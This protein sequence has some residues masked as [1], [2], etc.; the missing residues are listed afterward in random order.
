MSAALTGA[1]VMILVWNNLDTPDALAIDFQ[2][3]NRIYWCD[4]KQNLVESIKFDGTDRIKMY[5]VGLVNPLRLDILGSQIYWVSSQTRTSVT[6]QDKFGRGA[7]IKLIA[8]LDLVQD[9]KVFHSEK[10]PSNSN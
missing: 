8:D 1:D 4:H 6:K 7:F 5:H 10:V 3:N 2:S 9:V